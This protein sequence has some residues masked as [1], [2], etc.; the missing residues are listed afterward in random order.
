VIV[1]RRLFT[2][3]DPQQER[4]E[5]HPELGFKPWEPPWTLALSLFTAFQLHS[6]TSM[7]SPY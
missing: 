1:F 5:N 2:H 6:Y 4:S 7:R 3:Q